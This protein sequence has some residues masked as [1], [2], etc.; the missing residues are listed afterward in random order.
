MHRP[1]ARPV[2]PDLT[3]GAGAGPRRPDPRSKPLDE[4]V[5]SLGAPIDGTSPNDVTAR[6]RHREHRDPDRNVPPYT[7]SP[8]APGAPGAR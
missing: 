3:E 7:D 8:G 4:R 5:A 6:L 2:L 1:S